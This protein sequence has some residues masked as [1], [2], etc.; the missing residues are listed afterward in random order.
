MLY[1][2]TMGMIIFIAP[3]LPPSNPH[4]S[5]PAFC[6]IFNKILIPIADRNFFLLEHKYSTVQILK[7]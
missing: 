6:L 5:F 1:K 3:I 2:C 4:I 7:E